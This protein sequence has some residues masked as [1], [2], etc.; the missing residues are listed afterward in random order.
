LGV[1]SA[2]TP[3]EMSKIG[4]RTQDKFAI[5]FLSALVKHRFD[6]WVCLPTGRDLAFIMKVYETMGF[7]GAIGSVRKDV[8]C[9]FR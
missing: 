8:E 2:L 3:E 1:T 9:T 5:A 7:P 6:S 4:P